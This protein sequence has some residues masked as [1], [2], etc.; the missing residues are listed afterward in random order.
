M[1]FEVVCFLVVL[2]VVFFVLCPGVCF[3]FFV[4]GFLFTSARK[5]MSGIKV[6]WEDQQRINTYGRLTGR[7]REIE[8]ELQEL[9]EEIKTLEDASSEIT[10]NDEG[11]MYRMADCFVAMEADE[12]EKLLEREVK[13]AREKQKKL[14]EE[15]AAAKA[16]LAEL[17]VELV[18]H[19]GDA[20]A[21]DK[22]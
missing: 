8:A 14:S 10:L 22:N 4:F 6:T 12:A 5:N 18:R 11:L 13:V 3:W 1:C 19:F 21:L 9:E 7:R 16:S 17:K 2:V 20:I 15:N